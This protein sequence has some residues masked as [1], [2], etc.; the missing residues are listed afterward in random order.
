MRDTYRSEPEMMKTNSP[1]E[2]M[3]EEAATGAATAAVSN[4]VTSTAASVASP[5]PTSDLQLPNSTG[6]VQTNFGGL[7]SFSGQT[8]KLK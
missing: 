5:I 4:V 8:V 7:L 3:S 2:L 6:P 1:F